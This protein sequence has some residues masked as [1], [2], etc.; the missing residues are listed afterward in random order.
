MFTPALSGASR[1]QQE[2]PE[3][4]DGWVRDQQSGASLWQARGL[5]A[6]T[7]NTR[8]SGQALLS[9]THGLSTL[10]L[11]GGGAQKQGQVMTLPPTR[12]LGV[13]GRTGDRVLAA[14]EVCWCLLH[15]GD[16]S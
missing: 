7:R 16:R 9:M 4:G 13:M 8:Y 10:D 3:L 12:G 2:D 14:S 6:A 1:S 15:S 5:S 11:A